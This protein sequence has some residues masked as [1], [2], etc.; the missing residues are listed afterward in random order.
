MRT[1][2][3]AYLA[4]FCALAANAQWASITTPASDQTIDGAVFQVAWTQAGGAQSYRLQLASTVPRAQ[5]WSNNDLADLTTSSTSITVDLTNRIAAGAYQY[6]YASLTSS[7]C[8]MCGSSVGSAAQFTVHR[9]SGSIIISTMTSPLG[10]IR[11]APGPTT[12][13]FTQP[14]YMPMAFSVGST[15]AAG[16][17]Y[18][19]TNVASTTLTLTLPDSSWNGGLETMYLVL[20]SKDAAGNWA[21]SRTYT[22]QPAPAYGSR[23]TFLPTGPGDVAADDYIG[24]TSRIPSSDVP[25]AELTFTGSR[26]GDAF[27]PSDSFSTSIRYA[28]ANSPVYVQPFMSRQGIT[29]YYP[30]HD[31]TTGQMCWVQQGSV[32]HA[33]YNPPIQNV[34]CLLGNTDASGSFTMPGSFANMLDTVDYSEVWWVGGVSDANIVGSYAY[35]IVA[36][37][38][39]LTTSVQNSRAI[40]MQTT[41]PVKLPSGRTLH[42]GRRDLINVKPSSSSYRQAAGDQWAYEFRL[43]GREAETI[44]ISDDEGWLGPFGRDN[45]HFRWQ[46]QNGWAGFAQAWTSVKALTGNNQPIRSEGLIFTTESA[47]LPGPIA[48]MFV[49]PVPEIPAD[50]VEENDRSFRPMDLLDEVNLRIREE[51][52]ISAAEGPGRNS[53]RHVV[54]GPGIRPGTDKPG[55]ERLVRYWIKELHLAFLAPY[56]DAGADLSDLHPSNDLERDVIDCLRRVVQ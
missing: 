28:P 20:Y 25:R 36:Q 29:A 1:L 3:L 19:N 39:Q 37:G 30:G 32:F 42:V 15:F 44:H 22:L 48:V 21:Y 35:K 47:W 38:I 11:L 40:N 13:R 10:G 54:I 12:F 31:S 45:P 5:P 14:T 7:P 2:K 41:K 50:L 52:A 24:G 51:E 18:A 46:F 23:V 6:V 34:P 27:W 17:I 56:V 4:A 9:Q 55:L 43:D 26:G 33:S 16:D 49:G 8:P 53:V